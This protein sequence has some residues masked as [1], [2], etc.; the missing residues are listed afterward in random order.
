MEA[1]LSR[2]PT[3]SAGWRA[4]A[5]HAVSLGD[6][7]EVDW[8]ELKG[9]LS[10]DRPERKRPAVVLSR[11][12]LGMA[13]R[14]PVLAQKHLGGFGVV[15]VGID[16][17][18]VVGADQVDG[19]V[20][21]DVV[22]GYVGEDGP[23]WDHQF[24]EHP[25]GLLLA[26]VI[27]PPEWG[28]RIHACRKSY[29]ADD[30]KLAVRDGEVFVRQPGKTQPASSYDLAELER[31]SSQA[32]HSGAEVRLGYTDTFDR[33]RAGNVPELLEDMVEQSASE[34]LNELP[35]ESSASSV[36]GGGL[37]GLLGQT[38][39]LQDR[40][41]PGTFKVQVEKWRLESLASVPEVATEFLR[42]H[43]ARGRFELA[44]ESNRYLEAVRAQILFPPEAVVLMA[45]DTEYCEHGGGFDVFQLL[46]KSPK[47]WGT[48]G[49]GLGDLTFPTVSPLP[50]S[51]T[52]GFEVEVQQTKDGTLVTWHVGDL[53]PRSTESGAETFAVFTDAHVNEL[54]V[55]WKVTA[56][57]VDHVFEGD[58]RIECAQQHGAH[59][60]W[61]RN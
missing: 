27:D 31:R 13:N 53:R 5:D 20:L 25:D 37:A 3:G 18:T 26:I 38:A 11:A 8:L 48:D 39:G 2:L 41:T 7:S 40:R 17:Q 19:A 50:P 36:Y 59:A 61:S 21:R 30:G 47:S 33:I 52:S 56:R 23:T 4:L 16:G 44:N 45:S 14:M 28:D 46:P 12:I 22:Q 34:L 29:S 43:L 15:L 58:G 35:P 32:P 51:A 1:D 6:L 57:G 60:T 9:T 42:H 10:F 49:Y 54:V 24:I 55:W